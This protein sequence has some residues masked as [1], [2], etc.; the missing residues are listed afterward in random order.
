MITLSWLLGAGLSYAQMVAAVVGTVLTVCLAFLTRPGRATLLWSSA[1]TLAMVS[2]FSILTG[3]LNGDELWRRIALGLLLGVPAL[4]WSG[5]RAWWGV[6]PFTW[7]GPVLAVL[8]ALTFAVVPDDIFLAAY[9]GAFAVTGL[10][11]GLFF[12]DW[13]RVRARR[14]PLTVPFAVLSLAFFVLG[15]AAFLAPPS[16]ADL[17]RLGSAISMIVYTATAILAVLGVSLRGTRHIVRRTD[18]AD[19]WD[20]FA[21]RAE[22]R[23]REAQSVTQPLSVFFFRL[24]DARDVGRAAGEGLVLSLETRFAAAIRGVFDDDTETG[25]PEKGTLV[26]LSDHSDSAS[27]ELLRTALARVTS[28]DPEGRAPIRP[29]ASAGWAPASGL[30]Y[31]FLSLVYLA[32]EAAELASQRGGDRWERVDATVGEMLI[33]RSALR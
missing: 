19:E 6:R 21:A 31:D 8:A 32:R 7:A 29:S 23:M 4:L 25:S 11:A 5:F 14:D 13:V 2:M 3:E 26:V 27:R 28:I 10:F 16:T 33:S 15:V 9:R 12:F 18:T 30:G 17:L 20:S 22:G 24:D 1:F